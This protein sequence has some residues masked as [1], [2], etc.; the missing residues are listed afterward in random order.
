MCSGIRQH[1]LEMTR[2]LGVQKLVPPFMVLLIRSLSLA[3]ALALS[4][5]RVCVLVRA[6][7]LAQNLCHHS[8]TFD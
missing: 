8:W 1:A 5:A 2:C 3:L 7:S 4:S 6:F